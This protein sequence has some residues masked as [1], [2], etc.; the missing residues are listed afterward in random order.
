MDHLRSTVTRRAMP[1][2]AHPSKWGANITIAL[3]V[4]AFPAAI[5]AS[6]IAMPGMP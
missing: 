4:G 3:M 5:I 1:R 6:Y 2:A